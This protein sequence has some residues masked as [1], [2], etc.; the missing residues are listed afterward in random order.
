M[1]QKNNVVELDCDTN[2]HIPPDKILQQATGELQECLLIGIDQEG[3]EY[4]AASYAVKDHPRMLWLMERFKFFLM[5]NA[6]EEES[7]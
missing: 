7:E 1:K 4:F 3:N 5:E 2:L 6:Q